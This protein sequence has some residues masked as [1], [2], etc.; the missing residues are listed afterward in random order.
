MTASRVLSDFQTEVRR[1][2]L[3]LEE[4]EGFLLAGGAAL[5][6]TGL[7]ERPTQDVDLFT[8]HASVQRAREAL[9]DAAVARGWA[10]TPVSDSPTFSRPVLHGPDDLVVDPA[11]DSRPRRPATVTFVGPAF[12]PEELAGRKLLALP[13]DEVGVLRA[14][15]AAWRTRLDARPGAS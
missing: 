11:C 5:V 13:P 12:A 8:A 14:F 4:S 15:F 3:S 7:T 1:V 10:V 6:A 2:F 9:A